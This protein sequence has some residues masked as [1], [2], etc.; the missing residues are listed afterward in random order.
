MMRSR[1]GEWSARERAVAY[2]GAFL[3]G[4]DLARAAAEVRRRRRVVRTAPR[5]LR[6]AH[7]VLREH[8]RVTPEAAAFTLVT[9]AGTSP[10]EAAGIV[11]LDPARLRLILSDEGVVVEGRRTS[12]VGGR[13]VR[14]DVLWPGVATVWLAV[15][16]LAIL[17]ADGVARGPALLLAQPRSQLALSAVSAA[18]PQVVQPGGRLHVTVA[19]LNGGPDTAEDVSVRLRAPAEV[20]P[21][22]DSGA[23]TLSGAGD[24]ATGALDVAGLLSEAGARIGSIPAAATAQLEAELAVAQDAA[25]GTEI[26]LVAQVSVPSFGELESSRATST[27]QRRPE[28]A[29]D[30][31]VSPSGAVAPGERLT[32]NV[33]IRNVGTVAADSVSVHGDGQAGLRYLDGSALVDG[34]PPSSPTDNGSMG[35]A[36]GTVEPGATRTASF[37]TLVTSQAAGDVIVHEVRAVY[38]GADDPA[39]SGTVR[40]EVAMAGALADT[41]LTMVPAVVLAAALVLAGAV[42]L[43]RG[44][45]EAA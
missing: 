9:A 23:V 37:E 28:L 42:L 39:R 20:T 40:V 22:A 17:P 21:V 45:E 27:V 19:V 30:L 2:L 38:A 44:Q 25:D 31:S 36:V 10:D 35:V 7:T 6:T 18:R 29:V 32:W 24:G 26:G 34:A 1:A 11:G 8:V 3:D 43:R 5:V 13:P 15:L 33:Q 41:G 16:A 14:R 4:D 12:W